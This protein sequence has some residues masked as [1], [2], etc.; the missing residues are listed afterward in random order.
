MKRYNVEFK[1]RKYKGYEIHPVTGGLW[2]YDIYKHGLYFTSR[3]SLSECRTFI[4]TSIWAWQH[5]PV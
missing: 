2:K 3:N 5:V 1:V 4:N